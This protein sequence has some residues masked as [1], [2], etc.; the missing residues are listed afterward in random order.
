MRRRVACISG[1]GV[2]QP[3]PQAQLRGRC[4]RHTIHLFYKGA[5]EDYEPRLR[6]FL[7]CETPEK[8]L[9]APVRLTVA[10]E[11]KRPSGHTSKRDGRPL[12]GWEPIPKP[13]SND[14]DNLAKPVMDAATKALWWGDDG[15]VG[16]LRSVKFYGEEDRVW[17]IA[18]EI[19]HPTWA[20]FT[21]R[22]LAWLRSKTSSDDEAEEALFALEEQDG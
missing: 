4:P 10:C 5:I 18:E 14:V 2:P 17:V 15:M 16:D 20:A 13:A 21:R 1:Q 12:A 7:K 6:Y 9:R 3:R 19:P 8:P 22:F 11:Y